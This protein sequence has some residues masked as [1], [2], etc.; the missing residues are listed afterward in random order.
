[1]G[2]NLTPTA[3]LNVTHESNVDRLTTYVYG[4]WIIQDRSTL[5]KE[6]AKMLNFFH[7]KLL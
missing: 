7:G 6:N 5:I 3:L 2:M 4:C 1:M